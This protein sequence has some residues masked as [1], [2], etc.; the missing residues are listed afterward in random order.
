MLTA[1]KRRRSS[2]AICVR[3][4]RL[5]SARAQFINFSFGRKLFMRTWLTNAWSYCNS[6]ILNRSLKIFAV[7]LASFS[8]AAAALAHQTSEAGGEAN[9]KLPD[10]S[11]VPFLGGAIEGDKLALGGILMCI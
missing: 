9:L 8:G 4:R 11:S 2:P 7:A 1:K 10:L 5:T 6:E 3:K